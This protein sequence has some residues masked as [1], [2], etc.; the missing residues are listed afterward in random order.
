MSV[1]TYFAG[2]FSGPDFS[3]IFASDGFYDPEI[4]S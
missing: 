3:L 2:A 1:T 4:R